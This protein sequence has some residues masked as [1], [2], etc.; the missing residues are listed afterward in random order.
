MKIIAFSGKR[1]S[2]K[3][4]AANGIVLHLDA[5][6]AKWF[7]LD[8]ADCLKEIVFRYFAA[9]TP[10][11]KYTI[12]EPFTDE[13]SKTRIHPCGKTYRELLLII[14][15]DMFRDLW[16]EVWVENY[17]FRTGVYEDDIIITADVRFPNEVKCVQEL[18][19]HV[20]RL[21]RNP[22]ND[23]HASETALDWLDG[24]YFNPPESNS[25]KNFY[26]NLHFDAFIDN[27]EMSIKEC[28]EAV[29]KLVSERKWI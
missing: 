5:N 25:A 2:G 29:W 28:R 4:T 15:T 16:P 3:T 7:R 21:L 8:F 27:R 20:I 12:H 14:G 6:N 11:Y 9:L 26:K 18:G 13:Q 1:G 10:E 23:R 19:G 24:E 22:Y 17:K